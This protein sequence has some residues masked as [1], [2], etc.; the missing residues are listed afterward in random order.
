MAD[1]AEGQGQSKSA[2]RRAA[3]R[4]AKEAAGEGVAPPAAAPQAK[5]VVAPAQVAPPAP[6][7][8]K[9]KA[10]A[11]AKAAVAPAPVPV[12][13]APAPPAPKSKAKAKKAK[14]AVEEVVDEPP[15]VEH[16]GEKRV[17]DMVPIQF[18]DG[19]GGEWETCTGVSKKQQRRKEN[20]AAA[21][22]Q[23]QSLY[24]QQV[25]AKVAAS[26]MKV[27]G[28]EF[29]DEPKKGGSAAA[30]ASQSLLATKEPS[31]PAGP[32]VTTVTIEV[33]ESRIGIVIGPKGATIKAIQ[34]KSG[35]CRIDTTNNLFTLT[36]PAPAVQTA[37]SAMR[38]LIEKGYTSLT[39]DDFQENGVMVH[40]GSFPDIIGRKVIEQNKEAGY[41]IRKIKE[42]LGVEINIPKTPQTVN[43]GKKYK[44]GIAGSTEKVERAKE[45]LT[46][47][48]TYYH[49][50]LTHPE[51]THAEIEV[52]EWQHRYLIGT[53][54]SEMKHIQKNFKVRVYIPREY[55]YCQNVLVVGEKD[56]VVRASTY[57]EKILWNSENASK[58]RDR[59]GG[60][61]DF[62]EDDE[63]YEPWM[64]Q[65]VYKR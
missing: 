18:D 54:G 14:A 64:D 16:S 47:I 46:N 37:E 23:L 10:K 55:S 61:G 6:A 36:G 2:K 56:N 39:F 1:S 13:P 50:E 24:G 5:A 51:E 52:P 35:G 28:M 59:D 63:E 53:K 44:V 65:Y 8:P 42:A 58:G 40:A 19:T 3:A 22:A 43:P 21:A 17:E 31:K 34:E 32:P 33:P 11:K 27:V 15:R 7:A 38:D 57:I 41:V 30:L 45:V 4:K 20:K 25:S 9:S 26:N 12:E 60:G 48:A 62:H 49:D 29:L